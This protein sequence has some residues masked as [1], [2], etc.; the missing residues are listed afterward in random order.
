MHWRR[1]IFYYRRSGT[2]VDSLDPVQHR[3][4]RS[5]AQVSGKAAAKIFGSAQR[6]RKAFYQIDVQ[7]P[8]HDCRTFGF[9]AYMQIQ[10]TP[11]EWRM[12]VVA[13]TGQESSRYSKAT[14]VGEQTISLESCAV[15]PG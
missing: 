4:E 14:R 13:A 3:A 12:E 15:L 2:T 8:T 1:A 10:G 5:L 9:S 6:G 11:F 7:N